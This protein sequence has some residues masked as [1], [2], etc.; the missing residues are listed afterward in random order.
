MK[1][2]TTTTTEEFDKDGNIVTRT[3]ET[4]TEEDD[5]PIQQWPT[6]PCYPHVWHRPI[7]PT[8]NTGGCG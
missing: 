6:Y 1:K 3:T 8:C 7:E 4:I 2:V 5:K